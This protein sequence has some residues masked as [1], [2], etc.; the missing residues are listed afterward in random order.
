[1]NLL[2]CHLLIPQ[3][4]NLMIHIQN[5]K[6]LATVMTL[7]KT[8]ILDPDIN[9][10]NGKINSTYHYFTDEKSKSNVKCESGFFIIHVNCRSPNAS[11][12]YL[13]NVSHD[14]DIKFNIIAISKTWLHSD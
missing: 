14:R 13:E 4:K 3:H 1:M 12:C 7:L 6:L 5:Y 11:M 8:D 9:F 2:K 10:F